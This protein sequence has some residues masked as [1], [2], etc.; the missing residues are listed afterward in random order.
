MPNVWT[1]AEAMTAV[2]QALPEGLRG[3]EDVF[4]KLMAAAKNL[5]TPE[6]VLVVLQLLGDSQYYGMAFPPD[7]AP[8]TAPIEV[9]LS[10]P[11]DHLM[12]L[13]YSNEW[14]WLSA[15]LTSSDG[16]T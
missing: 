1:P 5:Q 10:F 12:H 2:L 3:G 11:A 14:Y 7:P 8:P 6:E 16:E 13:Q 4:P 9:G 15:N